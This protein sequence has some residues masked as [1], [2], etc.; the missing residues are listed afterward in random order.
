MHE[1]CRTF[2]VWKKFCDNFCELFKPSDDDDPDEDTDGN[3][4]FL[5][6]TLTSARQSG[7]IHSSVTRICEEEP[8]C[9]E[10]CLKMLID[11]RVNEPDDRDDTPS[12]AEEETTSTTAEN[13]FKKLFHLAREY[14][15]KCARTN[16]KPLEKVD[17][18]T[19]EEFCREITHGRE[20]FATQCV[21]SLT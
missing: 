20:E 1:V 12:K 13:V 16:N 14:F 2:C 6:S 17:S 8:K 21:K 10:S 18:I 3:F 5:R 7:W 11:P 4:D 9:V 19:G 15:A